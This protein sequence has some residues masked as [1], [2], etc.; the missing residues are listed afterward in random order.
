MR[1]LLVNSTTLAAIVAFVVGGPILDNFGSTQPAA[2]SVLVFEDAGRQLSTLFDDLAPRPFRHGNKT[3]VLQ[4][5]PCEQ[6][7]GSEYPVYLALSR[8]LLPNVAVAKAAAPF[9]VTTVAPM[10]Q[11]CSPSSCGSHYM[12][13]WWPP[14]PYPCGDYYQHFYSTG[15]ADYCEVWYYTGSAA[16]CTTP[17]CEEDVC[18]SC[19]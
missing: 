5:R 4:D 12:W 9:G 2:A 19:Q 1:V 14:C 10:L 8:W 18:N 16:C 15:Q 6:S 3:A 11:S 17:P 13:S 7:V